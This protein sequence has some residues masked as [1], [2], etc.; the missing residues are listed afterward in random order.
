MKRRRTIPGLLFAIS[1]FISL[2]ALTGAQATSA[3]A[4]PRLLG[5]LASAMFELD[6]WAPA[7]REDLRAAAK[8]RVRGQ[9]DVTGI[10][11]PVSIPTAAVLSSSDDA[12]PDAIAG[13]AGARL[14]QEGRSAFVDGEG[15]TGD[16]SVTQ[17]ARWAIA[18]LGHD[19]EA[20]WRAALLASIVSSVVFAT[21]VL[22]A[23]P[24]G[25][26]N[27]FRLSAI[28][29]FAFLLPSLAAWFVGRLAATSLSSPVDAELARM[30]H[31]VAWMAVRDALA[32]GFASVVLVLL[33]RF[34]G[35]PGR[36]YADWPGPLDEP[37]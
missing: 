31:D 29:G 20:L 4:G 22:F 30:A 37:V 3:T 24:A 32:V 36:S 18:L 7:H 1:V 11:V 19:N 13:A 23:S 15:G 35:Q 2:C 14:Y 25:P 34:A 27:V 17:P 10:P 26:A 12:L 21:L 8:D 5:R 28:A 33:L 16:I 6:R 9:V